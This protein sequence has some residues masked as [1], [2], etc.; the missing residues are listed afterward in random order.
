MVTLGGGD[1]A[2]KQT[3]TP[4][5]GMN[6]NLPTGSDEAS[7]AANVFQKGEESLSPDDSFFNE[8]VLPMP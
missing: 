5:I 2:I 1:I 6:V 8:V 3:E 4:Q 7:A